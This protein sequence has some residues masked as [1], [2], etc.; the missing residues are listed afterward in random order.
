M[1]MKFT[2]LVGISIFALSATQAFAQVNNDFTPDDIEGVRIVSNFDNTSGEFFSVEDSSEVVFL[3]NGGSET[4]MSNS[5]N[6]NIQYDTDNSGSGTFSLTSG[7]TNVLTANNAGNLTAHSAMTTNGINNGNDGIT[8]AGA[9]SGVTTLDVSGLATLDGG[10]SVDSN[11]AAANGTSFTINNTA[12]TT[13][14]SNGRSTTVVNDA[15]VTIGHNDGVNNNN[16]VVGETNTSSIGANSFD[17][18][19]TVNGGM[20]VQGDLG[21]NGS[22]YALNPTANTGINVANNGLDINGSTNTVSL[23]ADSNNTSSDGRGQ[24]VLQ[25]D[26]ASFLVYN[27]QNGNAHGLTV[28]QTQTVISGG[29]QSTSLTLD[30]AGATF[31]NTTSGGPAQV[32]G[33]AD[34]RSDFDAVNYRQLRTANAGVASVSAMANIPAP[35]M[36]KRFAVGVGYGNFKNEGAVAI[37]AT[38]A[39][40]ENIAVKTSFGRSND[41]NVVG[42]GVGFSW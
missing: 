10:L 16:I 42:A 8:N 9:V 5:N 38:A 35:T 11:G 21:V 22:I 34:G 39:V 19:T 25:E 30:D 20:L 29:T 37:G 41:S 17:Y 32:T 7:G 24:I 2:L 40:T 31:R 1:N 3:G 6:T 12:A 13:T 26:Q 18:G 36:G 14:S 28:N 15:N 33:V 4:T 27:Q 23:L